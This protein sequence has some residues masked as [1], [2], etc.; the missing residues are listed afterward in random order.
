[1]CRFP[2]KCIIRVL[3]EVASGQYSVA[4]HLFEKAV[5]S[6]GAEQVCATLK[7][8]LHEN[9]EDAVLVLAQL[10]CGDLASPAMRRPQPALMAAA[11]F[12]LVA[13]VRLALSGRRHTIKR[14]S[15]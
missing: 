4:D 5:V 1:M 2:L 13:S 7:D 9:L 6:N 15:S 14:S 12:H 8:A 11:T 3:L 10:L